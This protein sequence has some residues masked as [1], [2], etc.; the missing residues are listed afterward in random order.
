MS[1]PNSFDDEFEP[2]GHPDNPDSERRP[3]GSGLHRFCFLEQ[4]LDYW[5]GV[6]S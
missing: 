1:A 2:R 5:D 6:D 4:S 3:D